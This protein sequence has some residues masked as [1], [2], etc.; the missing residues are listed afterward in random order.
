MVAAGLWPRGPRPPPPTVAAVS[1]PR[2]RG[3]TEPCLRRE[4][5]RNLQKSAD[6]KCSRLPTTIASTG[7]L[8]SERKAISRASTFFLASK[9]ASTD[10]ISWSCASFARLAPAFFRAIADSSAPDGPAGGF[11]ARC[12]VGPSIAGTVDEVAGAVVGVHHPEREV[13]EEAPEARQVL[14]RKGIALGRALQHAVEAREPL[15]AGPR[16]DREGE[17]PGPHHRVAISLVIERRAP[18]KSHEER[19]RPPRGRRQVGRKERAH[20][21]PLELAVEVSHHAEHVVLA[22]RAVDLAARRA[23]PRRVDGGDVDLP[24]HRPPL[25][26]PSIR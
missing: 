19:G 22:H 6:L 16:S 12:R 9:S 11:S 26:A 15:A 8:F 7:T 4:V 10:V 2:W 25:A 14:G 24:A 17:M 18:E 1:Q 13:P 5:H 21:R 20:A 3:S 23:D